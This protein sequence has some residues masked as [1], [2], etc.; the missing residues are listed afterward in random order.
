MNG[1]FKKLWKKLVIVCLRQY[2]GIRLSDLGNP[3][4]LWIV[5]NQIEIRTKY[6]PDA[7]PK[8]YRLS[9]WQIINDSRI[10]LNI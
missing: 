4:K 7:S 10:I 5:C 8:L 6:L 2:S 3:G 9:F 1:E